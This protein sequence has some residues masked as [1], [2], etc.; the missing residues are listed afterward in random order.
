MKSVCVCVLGLVAVIALAIPVYSQST[1]T[2][3]GVVL[4]RDGKPIPGATVVIERKD[5]GLRLE[6]KADKNGRYIK[7]GLDDGNYQLQVIHDGVPI[8]SANE[9]ISLGFRV[10]HDFDL[11]SQS[12]Q[13][14]AG[15]TTISKAQRDAESKANTDTNGAFNAGLNALKA[16]N[17]DEAVKQFNLAAERK[18][19]LPVI[20]NRLGETYVTAK[21]YSEATEAYKKATE[22]KPDESEYFY[23][24]GMAAGNAG[25]FDV[26]KTAV[27]KSVDLDPARGGVAYFNL[28]AL[29]DKGGQDKD[30]VEAMQR[31]IKQNPKAA[32]TYYQ[33]G[34]MMMKN[35]PQPAVANGYG[36][37]QRETEQ[38]TPHHEAMSITIG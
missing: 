34:L 9:A 26:A 14:Q 32:E 7:T 12:K 38:T 1:G 31:S 28:G 11:Q 33:L 22:L 16:G 13:Q 18:P 36:Q 10:D 4:D 24:L 2:F 3:A 5:V 15:S 35:A 6:V 30:A 21:K 17:L 8:A 19:N 27:Q 37:K 20:Y 29:L 25:K 23:Q